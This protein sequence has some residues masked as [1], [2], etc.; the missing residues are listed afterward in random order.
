[1][2]GIN[3]P[4]TI[5]SA[6]L[7]LVISVNAQSIPTTLEEMSGSDKIEL[8]YVSS[9]E[10]I[11]LGG[12]V[13]GTSMPHPR[14]Y[15]GSVMY[16][17]NDT[18][19]LYVLGGDTTG[20]GEATST[21]LKYNLIT[22]TWEYIA[23]LPEPLR[24]NAAAILGDKIYTMGGFNARFPAPAVASFYEYDVN[25]NTW[26]QLPD[27]PD[28]LFFAGAEGFEDSLIYILGG[29][30]DNV[31]TEDLWRL[32]T[33]LYNANT[34][35][36]REATPMPEGTA[37]FGHS[38]VGRSLFVQGGL[39]STTENWN[40]TLKG[41]IDA[42]DR[43]SINWSFKSNYPLAVY[44]H[45]SYPISDDE[46]YSGGGSTTTGFNSIAN[47]YGFNIGANTY[48]SEPDLPYS[49]MAVYGGVNYMSPPKTSGVLRVAISGGITT[50][51][52]LTNQTWVYT[53][54]IQGISIEEG[55]IPE[56]YS[57]LQNF[58][59]P[60]NPSTTINFSIPEESF[61]SL[62]IFN[63]LGE[64]VKTLVAKDFYAGNYKYD[65]N[66][67]ELTSGIYFYRIQAGSF[68]EI[69]KML[70]LK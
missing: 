4:V 31:F 60:F 19:W 23:P 55:D 61:V 35:T 65:W 17:R 40:F 37:S 33:V 67:T 58:P 10:R 50:G 70:L 53:E 30:Q 6:F 1:M 56:K 7:L 43:A 64:E 38:L 11:T 66:A 51:P 21:C 24:T 5:T 13:Q 14:Y 42:T 54:T 22:D 29:I 27:L 48:E 3:Y 46:I 45:Y 62:Q 63:S 2:Q 15:G 47:A 69:K 49:Q 28:P 57:L 26:A 18:S 59:N 39:K 34:R 12:W 8:Q 41:D 20:G 9:F 36:F 16:T 52:A 44:A 25:T 32:H 68:V